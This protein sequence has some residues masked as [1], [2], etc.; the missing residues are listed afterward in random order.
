MTIMDGI[1]LPLRTP[2]ASRHHTEII[3]RMQ[4]FLDINILPVALAYLG[5]VGAFFI[6]AAL[7]IAK[8]R[9]GREPWGDK[10]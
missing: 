5:F 3:D 6:N 8:V 10:L 7:S 2:R 9:R 1:D 4:N